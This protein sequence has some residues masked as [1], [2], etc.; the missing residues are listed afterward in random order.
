[1]AR[2]PGNGTKFRVFLPRPDSV[3]SLQMQTTALPEPAKENILFVDDD[4]VLAVIGRKLLEQLGYEVTALTSSLKAL[5]VFHRDPEK[6][7]VVITDQAM[8]LFSGLKLAAELM[9]VRPEL[10]VILFSSLDESVSPDIA[11][12]MGIREIVKKPAPIEDLALAIRRVLDS[13]E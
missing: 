2:N 13:E 1:V 11:R 12:Q 10:P 7:D 6:F 9:K 8:P 4:P 3:I 5:E